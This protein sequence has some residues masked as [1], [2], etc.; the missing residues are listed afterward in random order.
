MAGNTNSGGCP[1]SAVG[2]VGEPGEDCRPER[3]QRHHDAPKRP[4]EEETSEVASPGL[5][6][7]AGV[8]EDCK[9]GCQ[10]EKWDPKRN[11]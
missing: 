5:E 9:R 1:E 3:Q 10:E 6:P 8:L 2:T 7:A 4:V 11:S